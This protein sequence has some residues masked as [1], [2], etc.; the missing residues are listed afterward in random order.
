MSRKITAVSPA[1]R[2]LARIH[3]ADQTRVEE[4][5]ADVEAARQR[6]IE[7]DLEIA[8]LIASHPLVGGDAIVELRRRAVENSEDLYER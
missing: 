3:E 1:E 6:L 4:L 7:L 5:Q 8:R 2:Q